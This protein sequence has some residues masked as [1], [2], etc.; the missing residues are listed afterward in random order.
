VL[1]G[2]ERRQPS[3]RLARLVAGGIIE[4]G[5][6][7]AEEALHG[8]VVPAISLAAHGATHAVAGEQTMIAM[9]RGRLPR[10][11]WCSWPARRKGSRRA[12]GSP[13]K[14]T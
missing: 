2:R 13:Q 9:S 14:M 1:P 3:R 12:D 11:E 7:V 8:G 10:S 4:L 6:H 5:F